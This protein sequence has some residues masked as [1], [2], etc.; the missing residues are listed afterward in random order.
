LVK[1][2][3][4]IEMRAKDAM[5]EAVGHRIDWGVV[6]LA[7]PLEVHGEELEDAS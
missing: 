7:P 6:R 5:R 2:S 3:Y 4:R 1:K